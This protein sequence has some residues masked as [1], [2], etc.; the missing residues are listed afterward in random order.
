MT[1][2]FTRKRL[3]GSNERRIESYKPRVAEINAL[4]KEHEA[5]SDAALRARSEEFKKRLADA[6]PSDAKPSDDLTGR[7]HRNEQ[8]KHGLAAGVR[9]RLKSASLAVRPPAKGSLG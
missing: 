7:T 9:A 1:D 2:A 3:D 6:K 8:D 5:L 4:E